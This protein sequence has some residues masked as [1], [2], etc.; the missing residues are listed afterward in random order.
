VTQALRK[1]G[2]D[3][4]FASASRRLAGFGVKG[5]DAGGG[6]AQVV[7]MEDI[8]LH[9]TGDFHAIASAHNLLS[10]MLDS[11]LHHG[12]GAGVSTRV[13]SPGPH[14]RHERPRPAQHHR[15]ARGLERRP[16][17]EE[18]F[19]IIPGSEIMAISAL[20]TGIEDWSSARAIIVGLTPDKKPV[21]ASD[22]KPR[23]P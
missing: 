9:F 4:R 22:L 5:G 8:N 20:A 2:K 3:A 1:I 11:H 10:A 19:V 7:P 18:R 13:A 12:N 14:H 6:Y 15:G 17:R 23:G 21:R 16:A